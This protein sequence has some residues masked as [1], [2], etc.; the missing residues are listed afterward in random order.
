MC[1]FADELRKI[2]SES[3]KKKS[4]SRTV[5]TVLHALFLLLI[6]AGISQFIPSAVDDPARLGVALACSVFATLLLLYRFCAQLS[7][8]AHRS[9]PKGSPTAGGRP[10]S[11][12][13]ADQLRLLFVALFTRIPRIEEG[14]A[15]AKSK[16]EEMDERSDATTRR[17]RRCSLASA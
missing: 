7:S 5:G 8:S 4:C 16:E 1:N 12:G 10:W 3:P 9:E 13:L 6:P 2:G 14:I 15:K 17:K 11:L